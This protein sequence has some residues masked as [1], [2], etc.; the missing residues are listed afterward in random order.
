MTFPHTNITSSTE[1]S[2][3]NISKR[4]SS[5][6][7]SHVNSFSRNVLKANASTVRYLMHMNNNLSFQI[8]NVTQHIAL[9]KEAFARITVDHNCKWYY[10]KLKQMNVQL[11]E[12]NKL[13][14]QKAEMC[15]EQLQ[16]N[17]K[18][19]VN[20]LTQA[21]NTAFI[22]ENALYKKDNQIYQLKKSL[23]NINVIREN[24]KEVYD[25]DQV[26][27]KEQR[28]DIF[29]NIME[30]FQKYLGYCLNKVSAV[31]K[32]NDKK[33][34]IIKV[35][36]GKVQ[37]EKLKAAMSSKCNE[38]DESDDNNISEVKYDIMNVSDIENEDN[39]I[40]T[41]IS[42]DDNETLNNNDNYNDY[43]Y[44]HNR[45]GSN[46]TIPKLYLKQIT[47]NNHPT[48]HSNK[49]NNKTKFVLK[50]HNNNNKHNKSVKSMTLINDL[51]FSQLH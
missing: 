43:Y 10:N 33:E 7:S 46:V 22:Y 29:R 35:L 32:A 13:L 24:R 16:L 25:D 3:F 5:T 14:R 20:E 11:K 41:N 26:Y 39:Q 49:D 6:T 17:I 1:H 2:L 8:E 48:L 42:L 23:M 19:E 9:T 15:V 18:D 34:E 47:Y 4:S 40:W 21:K 44:V 12:E 27:T 30:Y 51:P 38:S 45:T 28:K 36:K 31:K 50:I 37:Q